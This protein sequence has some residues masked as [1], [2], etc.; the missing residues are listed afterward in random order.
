MALSYPLTMPTEVMQTTDFQIVAVTA[1]NTLRSGKAFG[2]EIAPAY[3]HCSMETEILTV[4]EHDAWDAF[5]DGL[6]GGL[7]SCLLYDTARRFPKAYTTFS[8]LVIAGGST[9]FTGAGALETITNPQEII[10][11]DLPNGFVLKRGDNFGVVHDNGDGTFAYSLHRISLDATANS[12]GV[13]T[14]DFQP[15]LS[16]TFATS[17]TVNFTKALG[18]FIVDPTSINRQR[19]SLPQTVTFAADQRVM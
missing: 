10:V 19:Q 3:W 4:A 15:P 14:L 11:E 17:D 8:G 18:E 2:T 1:M 13:V 7:Y 16:S 12:S 5:F 6:R 9:P